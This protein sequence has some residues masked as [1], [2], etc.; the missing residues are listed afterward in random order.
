MVDPRLLEGGCEMS[1]IARLLGNH[2]RTLRRR[3]KE[4]GTSFQVL[5]DDARREHAMRLL[6][7]ASVTEVALS[8]GFSETSAFTRAFRRWVGLPPREYR[9]RHAVA[10]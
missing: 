7:T 2:P 5:L 10:R 3:L 8:L 1:S 4:E 6:Q 9:A